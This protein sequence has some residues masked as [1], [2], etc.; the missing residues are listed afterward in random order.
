[1]TKRHCHVLH[2]LQNDTDKQLNCSLN[3]MCTTVPSMNH[4]KQLQFLVLTARY[5]N[6]N[7]RGSSC[8]DLHNAVN[9]KF[10]YN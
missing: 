1:M 10:N 3:V 2:R 6:C 9:I 4:T 5:E 7:V 8:V